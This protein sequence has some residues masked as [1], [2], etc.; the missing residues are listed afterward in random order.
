MKF[1]LAIITILFIGRFVSAQIP[2]TCFKSNI[3]NSNNIFPGGQSLEKE[4]MAYEDFNNDG[5]RDIITAGLN[6]FVILYGS[7]NGTFGL[8]IQVNYMSTGS[9][10]LSMTVADFNSDGIKDIAVGMDFGGNNVKIFLG[11]GVGTFGNA[12]NYASTSPNDMISGDFN[13]DGK[14]DLVI[15]GASGNGSIPNNV[16]VML[17]NGNGSFTASQTYT[18]GGNGDYSTKL[19]SADFNQ[20]S[21]P[22]LAVTNY[23][24]DV[25]VFLHAASGASFLSPVSYTTGAFPRDLQVADLNSDGFKDIVVCSL[26]NAAVTNNN[27]GILYGSST[28]TFSSLTTYTT[29]IQNTSNAVKVVVGDYNGDNKDDIIA[30]HSTDTYG[31]SN[32][33]ADSYFNIFLG[34]GTGNFYGEKQFKNIKGYFPA[35]VFKSDA[36]NDGKLDLMILGFNIGNNEVALFNILGIGNGDFVSG[37]VTPNP[38]FT[39]LQVLSEDINGDGDL[40]LVTMDAYST[41]IPG[42]PATLTYSIGVRANDG[43]GSFSTTDYYPDILIGSRLFINDYNGDGKKDIATFNGTSVRMFLGNGDDTFSPQA[44][45]SFTPCAGFGPGFMGVYKTADFNEDGIGDILALSNNG[46]YA[47]FVLYGDA[48]GHFTSSCVGI[49]VSNYNMIVED[50]NNDGHKDILNFDG[51][52]F[53][54]FLGTGAGTFS[55]ATNT[56]FTLNY[57]QYLKASDFNNDGFKDILFSSSSGT[58]VF[59]TMLGNGTGSF[60]AVTTHTTPYS[61][62]QSNSAHKIDDYNHDGNMDIAF[63]SP[64]PQKICIMLGTGSGAFV[65]DAAPYNTVNNSAGNGIIIESGDYNS[66][67]LIDIYTLTSNVFSFMYNGISNISLT[68]ANSICKGGST[69]I[70]ATGASTYSWS[71]GSTANNIFVNPS[72]TTVYS[73]TSTPVFAGCINIAAKNLL[74]SPNPTLSVISNPAIACFNSTT[75][76]S[77]SGALTYSWTTGSTSSTTVI[78]PLS[79]SIYTVTG[80]NTTICSNTATIAVLVNPSPTLSVNSGSICSGQI[81]TI[82]PSGASTY[83]Y[84]SNSSTVSP[85]TNATYT[86]T[87]TDINGCTGTAV[88]SVSVN[89]TPTITVNSGSVCPGRTFTINPSGALTY[90][91]S[92]GSYTV[93]PS[94]NSIYTITGTGAN[95]CVNL[96]GAIS[97][98]GIST[99]VPNIMVNSGSICVGQTF[100]INPSGT[101]TYTYSSVSNTVAPTANS[102]YTVTG[103]DLNGCV[104]SIGAISSVT[105][106]APPSLTATQNASV[107]VGTSTVLNVS[108]ANTYSWTTGATTSSI[109]INP[110]TNTTYTVTGTDLNNCSSTQTV[111]VTVNQTCQDVWP[112]DANSDGTADNFDVLELGLHF[113]QTGPA[114]AI[115]SNAWQ[116]HVSNNWIGNISN[117]KNINHADCNGD[118]TINLNDSLAIYTNYGLTHAFKQPEQ[119][120]TDPQLS[121]VP[122]QTL[123]NKGNWGTS[124]VFLGKPSAPI[125]SINGLGFTVTFDQNLIDANSF[126]IEYP[127]SFLNA[128]NQ[129]LKFSKRDFANGKLYTATTHTITGNVYGNGK[130]AV[131][132]Y[133]IKSTLTTDEVLHIGIVQ[134]KQSNDAGIL[135]SLTAGTATVAAIGASVGMDELSGNSIGIFPNPASAFVIIHSS[136]SLEKIELLSITGQ[137]ILTEKISGNQHQLNLADVANGVYFV[138]VHDADQKVTRKKIVVQH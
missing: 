40:D 136:T 19:V 89:P 57:M 107:C 112:G 26:V 72:L 27:F 30:I 38:D 95:G 78:T 121:I 96:I 5:Y 93:T 84:S 97:S 115:T 120:A 4:V 47:L 70:S 64:T 76:L 67:G 73:V 101:N 58:N 131:L 99:V 128:S 109:T 25:S 132:H 14:I 94:S 35:K 91:Y 105:V 138:V 39:F 108:G 124:S 53:K 22:D 65:P 7:A 33:T 74:V 71:T 92:N 98:V 87:G 17:G 85:V 6:K 54:T 88:S 46:G 110:T 12:Y 103:T 113:T 80:F 118:G 29:I 1:F 104:N 60:T 36:N 62:T 116:P 119:T 31:S 130:I 61:I 137:I 20:D 56:A 117:G 9:G 69:T 18:T 50:F 114:R 77:A 125:T 2:N 41:Q 10:A 66:D 21:K 123:V 48:T 59:T 111:A 45:A 16:S 3:I 127:S 24:N 43:T 126:Y 75:T 15:A 79:T 49:N 135:T 42:Y 81:F 122:D 13:A 52:G 133:K 63:A 37:N 11:S 129:N 83:S 8:P 86:V 34:A 55:A 106:N 68:S 28:G 23:G 44:V 90:T 134:A 100:T 82:N 32:Y 102:T 51:A